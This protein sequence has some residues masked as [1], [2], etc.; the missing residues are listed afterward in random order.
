MIFNWQNEIHKN[1]LAKYEYKGLQEV[2]A[3]S[4]IATCIDKAKNAIHLQ[5]KIVYGNL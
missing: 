1:C 4:D 5:K 2:N 3:W